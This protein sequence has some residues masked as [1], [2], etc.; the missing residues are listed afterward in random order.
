M[1]PPAPSPPTP[2]SPRA[3]RPTCWARSTWSSTSRPTSSSRARLTGSVAANGAIDAAGQDIMAI[4]VYRTTT[5]HVG[6]SDGQN[7][8][9]DQVLANGSTCRVLL[10]LHLSGQ[11]D[12]QNRVGTIGQ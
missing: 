2:P 5:G 10:D 3:T 1:T 9:T 8:A 12:F 7:P 4:T 11:Y 6:Q